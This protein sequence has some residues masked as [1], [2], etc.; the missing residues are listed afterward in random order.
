MPSLDGG[1]HPLDMMV[2]ERDTESDA[3]MVPVFS[4]YRATHVDTG[5]TTYAVYLSAYGHRIIMT[6]TEWEDFKEAVARV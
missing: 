6:E 3:Y 1:G 2:I 4:A 5:A